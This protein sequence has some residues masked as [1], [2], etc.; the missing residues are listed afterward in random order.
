M[1]ATDHPHPRNDRHVWHADTVEVIE[2]G[3]SV[4]NADRVAEVFSATDAAMLADILRH[5]WLRRYL[6]AM[7]D[8][9]ECVVDDQAAL[10]RRV[11]DDGAAS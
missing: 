10:L 8:T 7:L 5:P 9:D 2:G 3:G 4:R 6:N 1:G 11:L